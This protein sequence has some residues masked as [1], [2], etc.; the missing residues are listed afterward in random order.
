MKSSQYSDTTEFPSFNP[1]GWK[2]YNIAT[3]QKRTSVNPAR[4]WMNIGVSKLKRY[5]E[6]DMWLFDTYIPHAYRISVGELR[7]ALKSGNVDVIKGE[8]GTMEYS[9]Y[10]DYLS[11]VLCSTMDTEKVLLHLNPV[12]DVTKY[13]R[14]SNAKPLSSQSS[15]SSLSY[16]EI[17][18]YAPSRPSTANLSHCRM[19]IEVEKMEHYED[20]VQLIISTHIR[21]V[22]RGA[23]MELRDAFKK[24]VKCI[25]NGTERYSFYID[26]ARGILYSTVSTD[27]ELLHLGEVKDGEEYKQFMKRLPKKR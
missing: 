22:Y 7:A 26:Y 14:S 23:I 4:C 6:D 2:N 17:I 3:T 15:V 10:I 11:H 19:N 25:K 5:A 27:N 16:G 24:G 8:D 18:I 20:A 1:G 13:N 21:R 9:F 12:K